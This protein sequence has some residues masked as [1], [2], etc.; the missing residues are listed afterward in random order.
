MNRKIDVIALGGNAIIPAGGDG[1]IEEQREVTRE[2]MRQVAALIKEGRKVILTHGNGPI[3]GN[4][5]ERNDAVSDRIPPMPI[6]VCGADSQGGIGYM[7]QQILGNQLR[8]LGI[9]REIVSLVSQVR[10]DGNDDAFQNPTKP[11]GPFYSGEEKD[12]IVKKKNW[13]MREDVDGRGFRRVVPSPTPLEIIEAGVISKLLEMDVIVIAVGGGGIPVIRDNGVL[14]GVEAVI[15]KDRAASVLAEEIG[16]DRLIILTNV[17]FV[18]AD[19]GKDSQ[20]AL[21]SISAGELRK[22]YRNYEF[23]AGSMGPKVRAALDFIESGGGNAV[24]ANVT[25]LLEACRS[26][27]GTSI[28]PG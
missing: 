12:R 15:D 5:I 14:R 19:Y 21:R 18:Y 20:K 27:K 16:A 13:M 28:Y 9:D 22:R 25:D 26:E 10:V 8:S 24:I 23:P 3:V 17:D 7:I 4:I 11:I 1:T 6:D 2:T